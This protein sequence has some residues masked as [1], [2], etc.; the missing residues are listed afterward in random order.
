MENENERGN[1]AVTKAHDW[2]KEL[3]GKGETRP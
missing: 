2:K 3:E 1:P